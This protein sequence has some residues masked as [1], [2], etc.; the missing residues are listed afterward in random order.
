MK[1]SQTCEQR[2]QYK[3]VF[4]NTPNGDRGKCSHRIGISIASFALTK[5]SKILHISSALI[6][7]ELPIFFTIFFRSPVLPVFKTHLTPEKFS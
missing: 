3:N 6:V 5:V 4:T 1:Q 2:V 7:G